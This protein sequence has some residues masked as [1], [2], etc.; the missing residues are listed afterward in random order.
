[1]VLV[2]PN[3]TLAVN[4]LEFGIT[5]QSPSAYHSLAKIVFDGEY[6]LPENFI[7]RYNITSRKRSCEVSV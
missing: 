7:E 4:E 2:E 5:I 3:I 1:V 6:K